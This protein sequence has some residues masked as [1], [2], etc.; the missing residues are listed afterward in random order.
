MFDFMA[1]PVLETP[2]LLLR[3]LTEFDAEDVLRIRGDAEVTKYNS[4]MPITNRAEA[5]VLI[6]SI[7]SDFR[8]QL[9]VRWGLLLKSN[10]VV[11]GLCGYNFWDRANRRASVGYDLAR[12]YWGRGLMPEALRRI[13]QFGFD[14]MNLNRVE[15][16]CTSLNTA[17]ARVLE[18]VG[19][20]S[21]GMQREQYFE[22][23]QFFDLLLFGLLR[24][25]WT[26]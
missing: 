11:V 20:K 15:A 21:E 10:G 12:A 22:Y 7:A 6:D 17:S 5:K 4:G 18:K 9:A 26:G 2:R 24:R 13:V 14:E 19:F 8:Q 1:F 16:D 23:G 3:E 25:D